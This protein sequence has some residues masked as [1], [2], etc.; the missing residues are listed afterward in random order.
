VPSVRFDPLARTRLKLGL[1]CAS[2]CERTRNWRAA[3][4][5]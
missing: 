3:E 5:A 1:S 2:I 4:N